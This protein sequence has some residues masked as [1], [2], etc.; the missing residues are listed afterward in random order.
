MS[1]AVAASGFKRLVR[2]TNSK[3]PDRIRVG[4]P[5]SDSIDV[6]LAVAKG[7]QVHVAL[8]SGRSVLSPGEPTGDTTTI[9]HLYSP[10]ARHE[11]NTIRCIGLNYRSHAEEVKLLIPS[12]PSLFLKPST[13]LADPWPT[14]PSILPRITR[15]HDCGDYEAELAVILGADA[16]NVPE[17]TALDYVLGYTAANDISS[18]TPQFWTSQW[19][20]SKGFDGSCPIGPTVVSKELIPDPGKLRLR[21]ILN[22]NT[23]Q[24]CG[25]DD[26]IFSVS[27]LVAFLSQ[28]TTLPAGTVILTGTPAG[29]G[30]S[31]KLSLKAGDEFHA[32]IEPYV[33]TLI[34]R[35]GDEV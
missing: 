6:G 26:L 35:F 27:K 29:V 17:E 13:C 3:F 5:L 22:G 31:R 11:T 34:N 25:T 7:E 28:G 2:F 10:I 15:Q 9:S 8:F 24:D 16:K 1:R 33:G 20:F 4:Q 32:C 21:G 23:M 12:T 30:M 14:A 18:R 19:D